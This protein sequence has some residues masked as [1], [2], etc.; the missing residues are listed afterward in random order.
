MLVSPRP[1]PRASALCLLFAF[2]FFSLPSLAADK[3]HYHADDYQ[4]EAVLN[5]HEHKISAHAK[6]RI[7]ALDELNIATFHLHNLLRLTK[8]A[9]T[10]GKPLT[11]DRMPQ[12][13][14]VRVS[15]KNTLKKDESTILTFDYEGV[16]DSA[17]DSP[18]PGLKLASVSDDESYLLYAGYWFPSAFMESTGLLQRSM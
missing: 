11:A 1:Q 12:D 3:S 8:V 17:D 13:S 4:I 2:V 16:L 7:T 5:P 15:L 6:V 10:S 18:V 14:S 9:D